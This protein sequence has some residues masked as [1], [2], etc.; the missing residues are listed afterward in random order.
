MGI[1]ICHKYDRKVVRREP[2]SEDVYLRLLVKVNLTDQRD[3][4]QL[5]IA[6]FDLL[7]VQILGQ[8]YQEQVQPYHFETF[9]HV[10]NPSSTTVSRPTGQIHEDGWP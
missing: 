4:K 2:R 3:T 9:V 8:A 5:M 1:D 10:E 6:K 7:V